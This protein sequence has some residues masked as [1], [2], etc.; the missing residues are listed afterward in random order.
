MKSPLSPKHYLSE[1]IFALEQKNIF[2]KLWIFAGI[3]PA[4]AAHNAFMTREIGG[5]PVLLQNCSGKIRAFENLCPHRLM[6][7][8]TEEFGQTPMRCVYHGWTFNP[9]GTVRTI[10]TER[11]L[12]NY[13]A[14]TR[15]SMCMKQFAVHELGNMIFVCLDDNPLPFDD[16]FTPEFQEKVAEASMFFGPHAIHSS[17]FLDFNWKLMYENVVDYNHIPFVHPRSLFPAFPGGL[18]EVECKLTPVPYGPESVELRDL[19]FTRNIELNVIPYHWMKQALKHYG[20]TNRY[21]NFYIY[22]NVNFTC[23]TGFTFPIHQYHPVSAQTTQIRVTVPSVAVN[24][25]YVQKHAASLRPLVLY[26]YRVMDE[27]FDA[28]ESIQKSL[29]LDA[30]PVEH[31]HYE[32]PLVSMAHVYKS[33]LNGESAN[34]K[35]SRQRKSFW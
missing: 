29:R 12:Y 25:D 24:D 32:A 5:V 31:G 21:Y 30:P 28:L 33:L 8:Q 1:E 10:P 20:K 16:Q 35:P 7:V 23:V 4:L 9:D 15:Q 6:P 27:D 14:E 34:E 13:D 2:R 18:R 17:R 11:H 19:S 26:E 3:K 22:P